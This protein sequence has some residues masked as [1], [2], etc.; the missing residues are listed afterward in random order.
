MLAASAARPWHR[1]VAVGRAQPARLAGRRRFRGSQAASA[2]SSA[3]RSARAS[4]RSSKPTCRCGAGCSATAPTSEA[5]SEAEERLLKVRDHFMRELSS[6]D[7]ADRRR[8]ADY[9]CD[10]CH[11]VVVLTRDIDRAHRLFT[12]LNERGRALQRNDILKAELL[13]SIP[14]ERAGRGAD[15]VGQRGAAARREVRDVL[16]PRLQ[17]STAAA[18]RRSSPASA[19]R[20][21]RSAA[22]GVPERN[23]VEPLPKAYHTVLR[24][25][26]V[27]INLDP[28]ARR[29]LVYLG[30]LPE[31]D[32][33]PAAMLA[34]AAIRRRSRARDD[35]AARRST[36]SC[37]SCACCA[38]AAGKRARRLGNVVELIK[39]ARADATRRGAV[40]TVAR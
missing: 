39:S 33:A 38:S 30:R 4:R 20:S 28:E 36:A 19:A 8:L 18:T 10:Q 24:A 31:G 40:R 16:Q 1:A 12:V 5:A 25:A 6:L 3:S 34:R 11:F 27:N 37:I 15:N 9:L 13:K 23:V 17:P 14:S 29:Y 26:D 22:R 35:A 21:A 32:W 2:S 7:E